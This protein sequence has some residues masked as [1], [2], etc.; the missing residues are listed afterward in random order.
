M[1]S[2]WEYLHWKFLF[3]YHDISEIS[4]NFSHFYLV[5]RNYSYP[6]PFV[7]VYILNSISEQIDFTSFKKHC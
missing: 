1:L 4:A 7:H 6:M 2:F 3:T 5:R